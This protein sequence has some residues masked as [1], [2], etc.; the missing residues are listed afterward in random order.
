METTDST[1]QQPVVENQKVEQQEVKREDYLDLG[2]FT[3][4]IE[5]VPVEQKYQPTTSYGGR[6]RI[7][8]LFESHEQF[9]NKVI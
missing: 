4:A 2:E 1:Q 8:K 5:A 9:M 6:V 3:A 7:A